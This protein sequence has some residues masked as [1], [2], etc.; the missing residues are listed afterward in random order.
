MAAETQRRLA[1]VVVADVA[2]YSRMMGSDEDGT[3]AAL[4]AHR[5][6]IDPFVFNAG[7]QIIKT[8][9]DGMLMEFSSVM[10]AVEAMLASQ[11][12]MA[13]RNAT[14]PDD[15]RMHFRIGVH[16][17]EIIADDGDI[18]GDTVN[19][20]ARLQEMAE[21]GGISISQAVRDSVHRRL[22]T[23]LMDLGRQD[24][25]N[26]AEPVGVWRVNMGGAQSE[27]LRAAATT[28]AGE[29]S[30]VAVLP[31]NNMSADPEQDYFA[32]GISEDI[33]AL[34]SRTPGLRVIARNSTFS[35]KGQATDVR[36]IA[37][38]L[39]A[40]YVLEGSVRR[41]GQQVRITAQLIDAS[42]GQHIWAERY[43]RKM[44][45]IFEVQDE[46]TGN[47]VAR[48]APEVLRSEFRRL[49]ERSPDQMSAWELYLR[50]L[51]CMH[52]AN[53]A[54][55]LKGEALCHQALELDPNHAAAWALLGDHQYQLLVYGFRKGNARTW[56]TIVENAERA[57]RLDPGD[58]NFA[59]FLA[60][61]LFWSGKWDDALALSDRLVRD[62]PLLVK[63]RLIRA[64]AL[65]QAGEHRAAT[66]TY[67]V[68]LRMSP[69]ASDNYQYQTLNA[70]AHYC[71]EN[72]PAALSWADEALRAVAFPQALGI[73]AAALGQ[74]GPTDEASRAAARFLEVFPD[75]TATR[76]CRNFRWRNQSDIDRYRDGLIKAG[77][78]E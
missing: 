35:Y 43:D 45:D 70:F 14:L 40:R 75:T 44:D 53:E 8:T 34:L 17:G 9:G 11:Q 62:Y 76:H 18:F 55:F 7:G 12:E 66:E 58:P 50:A 59:G 3:L 60:S 61:T 54:G 32:D 22:A 37:A 65:F 25:K 26:I 1:A 48:I 57:M 69:N 31:F 71:L 74:L 33:I 16:V 36:L 10:A 72:Y 78:P 5:N 30:A 38:E 6:A 28:T 67:D 23:P 47:I 39:D 51:A 41:S 68:A 42:N 64:S 21:P 20:A 77:L 46:I 52:Q 29:R 49:E 27:A 24:L 4:K 19:I 13:R 73:R 63:C 2:G 56:N 15:R